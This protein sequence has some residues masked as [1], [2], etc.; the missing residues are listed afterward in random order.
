MTPSSVMKV[1]W[2]CG[3]YFDMTCN[4]SEEEVWRHLGLLHDSLHDDR[5][6][7]NIQKQ[8]RESEQ[9]H[10]LTEGKTDRRHIEAARRKLGIDILLGYPTTDESLGDT[11]LLQICEGL[12]KFGPPNRNKLIAIF[13]R[14]NRQVMQRLKERGP[15]DGYQF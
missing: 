13:D 2:K 15:L 8:L 10:V 9:P 5:I 3:L 12:A 14:D 11:K 7:Q 4:T 1:G 6:V